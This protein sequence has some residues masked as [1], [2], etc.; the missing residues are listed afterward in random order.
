MSDSTIGRKYSQ[1]DNILTLDKTSEIYLT[2]EVQ[3]EKYEILFGDGFFGKKLENNQ[4]I[5]ATYIVTD[6]LDG[7][8]PSEFSFQGTFS[9]DDGSFFTPSDNVDITTVRNASN[10]AEVED[11]SSIKYLSLIHI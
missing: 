10:G 4:I 2:Q 7:N 9:K 1:V 5:T 8:G 6:G 3:D 11:V